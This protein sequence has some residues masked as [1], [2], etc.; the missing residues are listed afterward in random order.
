MI[1]SVNVRIPKFEVPSL[2]ENEKKSDTSKIDRKINV[3]DGRSNNFRRFQM[4]RT[5]DGYLVN[6]YSGK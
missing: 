4:G 1:S 5:F 6:Q 2:A 3:Q